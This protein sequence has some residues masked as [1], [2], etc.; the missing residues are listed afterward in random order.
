[1]NWPTSA[2]RL[3]SVSFLSAT[4][5]FTAASCE[6]ASNLGVELPGTATSSTDY[7][8]FPVTAS[9]ILRDSI[10]T[11][12]ATRFLIGRVR[13]NSLGTTTATA[14]LNLKIRP[15]AG[16]T[17]PAGVAGSTPNPQLDSLVLLLPF[18]AVYGSANSPLRV[19]VFQLAQPLDER[20]VYNSSSSVAL[21]DALGRNLS[22]RLNGTRRERVRTN[23]S[24][25]IDTSTVVVKSPDETARIKLHGGS[26]VSPLANEV[27]TR[28]KSTSFNQTSL[29]AVWKGLAIQPLDDFNS[30]V[31]GALSS[32]G[33]RAVF[34]YHYTNKKN[35]GTLKGRYSIGFGSGAGSNDPRYFTQISNE[36][37]STSP[38]IRLAGQTGAT[39]AVRADETDG[40]VYMQGGNG[41]GT[42]LEIPGLNELKSLVQPQGTATPAIA[43]NRA[44]LLIPVKPFANLLFAVPTTSYL[45]EVN[46][47]NQSLRRLLL[48]N[49]VERIVLQDGIDQLGTGLTSIGA[50]YGNAA[51]ADFYSLNDANSYYSM[52]LTGYVQSYVYDK[53][54]GAA[55]AAFVLSPALRSTPEL[56]LKRAVLDGTGIKLRVYYSQLR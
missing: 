19:N 20:T 10:E 36:L 21:G 49:R 29:D 52:V 2:R 50:Y 37:P 25:T 28:L 14:F 1:M 13:D 35:T 16:D 17:L 38:L 33:T 55:P 7:R 22:A 53:L 3:G 24:S 11:Q 26:L 6:D 47:S 32:P 41:F 15:A 12:K 54:S 42:R 9:T 5:L 18:D 4:L 31:I 8:D 40:Q 27:F 44:E 39:Q 34:Y 46:A 56:D 45:Y 30:A 48:N 23:A 51:K 43:I